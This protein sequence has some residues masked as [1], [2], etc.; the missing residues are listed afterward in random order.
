M[1][2]RGC[3]E[4]IALQLPGYSGYLRREARRDADRV[5]RVQLSSSLKVAKDHIARLKSERAKAGDLSALQPLET[6]TDR[7]SRLISKVTNADSGYSGFFDSVKIDEAT[8]DQIHQLDLALITDAK[9]LEEAAAGLPRSED[10]A[11][12]V[13]ALTE[14]VDRFEIEFDRRRSI[15]KGA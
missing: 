12:A 6:A 7:L 15:L 3:L 11:P 2:D 5:A 1:A 4:E 13:A 14:R 9:A 8:L 10:S